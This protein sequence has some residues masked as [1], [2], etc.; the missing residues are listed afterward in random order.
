VKRFS[1]Y[2]HPNG[3]TDVVKKGWSWPAFLFTL[4]WAWT[5]EIWIIVIPV[6]AGS[7]FLSTLLHYYGTN[8]EMSETL[9]RIVAILI[10][11]ALGLFGNACQERKLRSNDFV[12]REIIEARRKDEALALY[13]KKRDAQSVSL[14]RDQTSEQ[15]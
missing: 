9:I 3:K 6:I 10:C 14:E 11:F 1:I 5:E 12:F 7:F 13:K 15:S 4:L 2:E 8:D